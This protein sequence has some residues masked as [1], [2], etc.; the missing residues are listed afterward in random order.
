MP[1]GQLGAVALHGILCPAQ[2]PSVQM[3]ERCAE[4]SSG[5]QA[6]ASK[7]GKALR[8]SAREASLAP[9]RESATQLPVWLEQQAAMEAGGSDKGT[10]VTLPL[11]LALPVVKPLHD[12][13]CQV[14]KTELGTA[15]EATQRPAS[16]RRPT[17]A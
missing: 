7:L 6:I 4:V 16:S 1:F 13:R 14:A 15:A 3:N 8:Q 2:A 17:C 9:A 10:K 12:E 5:Q 11:Q